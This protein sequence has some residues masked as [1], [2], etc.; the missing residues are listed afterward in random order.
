MS[1]VTPLKQGITLHKTLAFF[2]HFPHDTL[3]IR[4]KY[5]E[6]K[7]TKR[8]GVLESNMSA[9]AGISLFITYIA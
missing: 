2:H 5:H 7:Q 9:P 4:T 1:S 6:K 8:Q 3:W